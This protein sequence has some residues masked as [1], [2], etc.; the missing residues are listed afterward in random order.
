M[1]PTMRVGDAG[2]DQADIPS[3]TPPMTKVRKKGM[4]M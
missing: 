2:P 3:A 4:M 1:S